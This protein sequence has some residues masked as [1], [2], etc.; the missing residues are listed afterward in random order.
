MTDMT[1]GTL[2]MH[3]TIVKVHLHSTVTI[4]APP[5]RNHCS[6]IYL[7]TPHGYCTYLYFR[8]L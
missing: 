8:D 7:Y 6:R 1:R 4:T 3:Y 2:M 5:L